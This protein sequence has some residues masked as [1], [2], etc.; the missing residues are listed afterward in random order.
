MK[1]ERRE[2]GRKEEK[3]ESS[4]RLLLSPFFHSKRMSMRW[5]RE[6]KFETHHGLWWKPRSLTRCDTLL[7]QNFKSTPSRG[8]RFVSSHHM[9]NWLFW[10]SN[11]NSFVTPSSSSTYLDMLQETSLPVPR[12]DVESG[13]INSSPSI[14]E[15]MTGLPS[16]LT[17]SSFLPSSS[18]SSSITPLVLN[19]ASS[20]QQLDNNSLPPSSL[21]SIP[22]SSLNDINA[23]NGT[24][25]N[26]NNS[27]NLN[28]PA[29]L[30]QQPGAG[31]LGPDDPLT[32][33][34]EPHTPGQSAGSD[35]YPWMK[36]K[37][38]SRKQSKKSMYYNHFLLFSNSIDL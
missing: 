4:V 14:A 13:F 2:I 3:K 16:H 21:P 22:H 9:M 5:E 1:G 7:E 20:N 19:N 27:N 26:N 35:H 28:P 29:L 31:I 25:I 11:L 33:C 18:S 15:F 36:E 38:T 12:M 17:E 32:P 8:E 34:S 37:K 30:I 6:E 24:V 10:S 23:T